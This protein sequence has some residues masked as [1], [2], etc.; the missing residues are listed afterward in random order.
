MWKSQTKQICD[1]TVEFAGREP[2]DDG[3]Q[4]SGHNGGVDQNFPLVWFR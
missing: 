2:S 1:A 4:S 3:N